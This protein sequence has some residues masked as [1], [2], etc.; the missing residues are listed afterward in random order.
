M[1]APHAT[2]EEFNDDTDV[3]SAPHDVLTQFDLPG[4]SAQNAGNVPSMDMMQEMMAQMTGGGA[5]SGSA[6]RHAAP[7]VADDGEE[8]GPHKHWTCVYPIYLDAKQR[9]RK[10]CRR[11]AYEKAVLHPNSQYISNAAK[12]LRL[13]YMHEPYRTHPRD[14]AN[15][16][17]VK[18]KLHKDDGSLVRS[19]LP[20]KQKLLEALATT[21]QP[22][23]GGKPPPLPVVKQP[24]SKRGAP[25]RARNPMR[26]RERVIRRIAVDEIYPPHSPAVPAGM[27]GMDLSKMAGAAGALQNMGPLGSMMS[28]MG[29]GGDDDEEEEEEEKPAAPQQPALGRRQRKRVVRIAR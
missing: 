20:T 29:L 8:D 24:K 15:P 25:A 18:I 16:G 10:G 5:S 12:Q 17:R 6:P 1:A 21:L 22:V 28:S 3:R 23:A 7:N 19:D 26:E 11:V 27:L 4:M 9:Y 13:E 14:W 2:V